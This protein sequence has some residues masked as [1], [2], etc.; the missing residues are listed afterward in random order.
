MPVDQKHPLFDA[1]A[2][3]WDR[4][5]AAIAG[6]DAIKA[7]G[8]R[9]LPELDGQEPDEY[10]AYL[11][12]ATFYGATGRTKVA[13]VGALWRKA[14]RVE[15]PAPDVLK[16]IGKA[17]RSFDDLAKE[18][19]DQDVSIGRVGMLV[20]VPEVDNGRPFIT[21]YCGERIINW[22]FGENKAGEEV[23]VE[24]VLSE[25]VEERDPKDQFK[26]A[27]VERFR[28][29]RLG[30]A[31]APVGSD[32]KVNA[33]IQ[34]YIDSRVRE[35]DL[36]EPYYYQE[37][38][39]KV[40]GAP[41]EKPQLVLDRII[42]P[43]MNGGRLLRGI[44]FECVNAEG[45]G[46]E[47][48]Q[49]PLDALSASNLSHWRNSADLEHGAHY[50][51]LPT[52]CVSGVNMDEEPEGAAY[53]GPVTKATAAVQRPKGG[54]KIGSVR[55]WV[56]PNPAAQAWFLEFTGAGLGAIRQLMEDKKKEMAALGAR[57]LEEPATKGVEASETVRL[58]QVGERSVL[59]NVSNTLS[60][61]L[62]RILQHV[63][64][65]LNLSG[66]VSVTLNDDFDTS[67]MDPGLLAS[68]ILEVQGGLM[69]W[70]TLY[71]N[72][73]RKS[74]YPPGWTMEK[75]AAAIVAGPPLGVE[76]LAPSQE[77]ARTEAELA[78]AKAGLANPEPA[79]AAA[80]KAA[81]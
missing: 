37:L 50:T 8:K 20:D 33:P 11:Q 74:M 1:A 7:A 30:F 68:M 66:K 19:S 27:Y 6:E 26:V 48:Q 39:A 9:F 57:L 59:A 15:F 75:E 14:P 53:D 34:E 42:I 78:T 24:I 72:C 44:P 5:R 29:L 58:R 40:Q 52:A 22:R 28:V 13:L 65:W 46:L 32:G 25:E 35:A 54:L 47:P 12:R 51:A 55:A 21:L 18:A 31:E 60:Q 2:P 76:A 62:T 80:D 81:A 77:A 69:S 63:A 71:F 23:P 38:W 36:T 43:W 17:G 56:F 49:A 41:G 79:P 64:T 70:Q 73:E 45:L 10:A 67:G 61:G 16:R 4:M 3:A